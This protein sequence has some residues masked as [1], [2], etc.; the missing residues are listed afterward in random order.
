MAMRAVSRDFETAQLM[1][2]KIN[3]VISVTFVIGS[4]LAARGLHSVLHQL[5]VR[6]APL[7]GAMPGLKAFVAAV[8][9]GIGSIPGAVIGAFIIGI[10]ETLIKSNADMA[11][12]SNAFTFALL[13]VI[14]LV[15]AQRP[16]RRK[17]DG[18]GVRMM[19]NNKEK[20]SDAVSDTSAAVLRL[21][22]AAVCGQ[23]SSHYLHAGCTV[24]KK[25][26]IYSLVA[27]SHEP[28]ERL[29]RVCSLWARR[30]LCC[31]AHIPMQS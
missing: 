23:D 14:L 26:A 25:G 1:G 6:S 16:V 10:C 12:F 29:Y 13:I 3:S 2:I 4:L 17:T 9:G 30:A 11:V 20:K 21:L 5:S 27:V 24:L 28:A 31:S 7:I 22:V 19:K 18:E 8:F 15:Q